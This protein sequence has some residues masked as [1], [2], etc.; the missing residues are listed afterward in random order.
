MGIN[1]MLQLITLFFLF[2]QW[3]Y[4]QVKGKEAHQ[5]PK[6]KPPSLRSIFERLFNR[7][8]VTVIIIQ[9]LGIDIFPFP[10][11]SFIPYFGLLFLFTGFTISMA[12]RRQLDT[13]WTNSYEYQI[14]RNHSIVTKGIYRYIRHPIYTGIIFTLLGTQLVVQSY[15]VFFIPIAML[16]CYYW[17]KREEKILLK[18]FGNKY[19][20]YMN[21]TKMFIPYFFKKFI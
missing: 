17:G 21:K 18:H 9:L 2:L 20:N 5:K 15:L 16:M 7:I 3:L 6:I 1:N 19:K 12:A 13:N 8:P 14:K 4:W 10:H 11:T